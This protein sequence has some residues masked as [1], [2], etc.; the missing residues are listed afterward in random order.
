MPLNPDRFLQHLNTLLPRDF[1]REFERQVSLNK[2][3]GTVP[4]VGLLTDAQATT[5]FETVHAPLYKAFKARDFKMQN[6]Y[7]SAVTL[8]AWRLTKGLYEFDPL[9]IDALQDTEDTTVPTDLFAR[10]P[11]HCVYIPLER[12]LFGHSVQGVWLYPRLDNAGLVNLSV[13]LYVDAS[14][15]VTLSVSLRPGLTIRESA[16]LDLDATRDAAATLPRD[17]LNLPGTLTRDDVSDLVLCIN[18]LLYLCSREPDIQGAVRRP[19]P[20]T[21]GLKWRYEIPLL[22]QTL[23]VGFKHGGVI[24]MWKEQDFSKPTPDSSG[25]GLPKAPHIRRA[26][27][28]LYWTGKGRQTPVLHWIP[29]TPVNITVSMDD[30]PVSVRPVQADPDLKAGRD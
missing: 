21:K 9:L 22:T 26:H 23:Y 3:R 29:P 8:A 14:Q 11:E 15:A 18:L 24:R 10:V 19:A 12:R 1:Y 28:H 25:L 5:V 16:Q 6:N 4:D 20:S 2:K 13:V 17:Q 7:A 27:W 30:F